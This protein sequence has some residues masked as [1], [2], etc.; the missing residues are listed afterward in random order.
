M[1]ADYDR[2]VRDDPVDLLLHD[3]E[4]VALVWMVLHPDHLLIENLAVAPAHQG[5]GHGRRLLAH[6]EAF[7][8][9][10]GLPVVR[11]Y[12]NRLFAAN[13]ELYLRSGYAIDREEPFWG[14][15]KVHMSKRVLPASSPAP[16]LAETPHKREIPVGG[17]HDEPGRWVRGP[18]EGASEGERRRS[19]GGHGGRMSRQ[20][21]RDAV[22]R[23]LPGED[24]ATLSRA[25]GVTAATLTG[26]QAAFLAAGEASLA[27][28]PAEGEEIESG[29]LKAWLGDMRLERELLEARIAILQ[30][31]RPL[32]RPWS[33]R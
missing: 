30:G 3:G 16:R 22:L 21:K 2:I 13:V 27:T 32:A 11:L 15:V 29:R 10:Q 4:L 26:W 19:R 33:R 28:R 8:A 7:A 25:L 12:T 20:R 17:D 5:R 9:R 18:A 14:G 23:L 31:K 24:L 1:T 6:A